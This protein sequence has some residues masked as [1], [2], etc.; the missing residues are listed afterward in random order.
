MMPERYRKAAPGIVLDTQ[1]L[2]LTYIRAPGPGGQNVNKVATA[3]QLRFDVAT[4]PSLPE[5]VRAR[6]ATLAGSRLTAEGEIVITAHATR[7]QARN[8]ED[9][10]A[11]LLALIA[12]AATPPR[13]R[14]KTAIPRAERARRLEAKRHTAARKVTRRPPPE[15]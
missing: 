14:H 4:S 11:Q 3:A 10:I 1:E 12:K 6:L 15:Q 2:R 7:S 13:K 9:A 5:P 8:R